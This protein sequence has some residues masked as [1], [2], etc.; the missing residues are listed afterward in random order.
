LFPLLQNLVQQ[1]L[2][3]GCEDERFCG[4]DGDERLLPWLGWCRWLLRNALLRNPL[5]LGRTLLRRWPACRPLLWQRFAT[6]RLPHGILPPGLLRGCR[7]ASHGLGAL[8]CTRCGC[9]RTLLW[10]LELPLL[11]LGGRSGAP[12]RWRGIVLRSGVVLLRHEP[13]WSGKE[14]GS[15]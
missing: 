3:F 11:L 10:L 1:S 15:N 9:R 6:A 14:R 2:L 12:L 4:R 13:L 8:C 5:L 7:S